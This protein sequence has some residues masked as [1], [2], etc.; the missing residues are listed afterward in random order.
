MYIHHDL[1]SSRFPSVCQHGE[2][3]EW[4]ARRAHHPVCD[5][6]GHR[7]RHSSGVRGGSAERLLQAQP[8]VCGRGAAAV[9]QA[10]HHPLLHPGRPGGRLWKLPASLRHLPHAQDAQRHQLFHRKPG[11][12]RHADVR[13]VRAL[14]AGLCLQPA[15]LGFR[16]IYVLPG[17]PHPAGDGVRVSLHSHGHWCGQVSHTEPLG[18][19]LRCDSVEPYSYLHS[20]NQISH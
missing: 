3:R 6:R 15:R 8:P 10:A 2:H 18:Q 5:A 13:Y 14:H 12:L 4:L 9:L 17:V 11:L 1:T 19:W 16:S 20:P 7:E